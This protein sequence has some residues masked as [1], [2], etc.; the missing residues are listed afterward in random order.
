MVLHCTWFGIKNRVRWTP[1]IDMFFKTHRVRWT[2]TAHTIKP[3]EPCAMDPHHTRFLLLNHVRWIT[4]HTRFPYSRPCAMDS[5]ITHASSSSTVCDDQP[6]T[7][8]RV[9]M[10]R[11]TVCDARFQ[12][13]ANARSVL[14]YCMRSKSSG[15]ASN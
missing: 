13:C 9:V 1:L 10:V 8:R 12:P 7:Y 2:P 5:P 11:E 15:S 6:I 4:H 3:F 14:V